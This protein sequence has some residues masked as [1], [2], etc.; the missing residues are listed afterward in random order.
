MTMHGILAFGNIKYQTCLKNKFSFP[1]SDIATYLVLRLNSRESHTLLR[2]GVPQNRPP[3]KHHYLPRHTPVHTSRSMVGIC[4]RNQMK[5][6]Y[7]CPPLKCNPITTCLYCISQNIK[8]RFPVDH[9][10]RTAIPCYCPHCIRDIRPGQ[11]GNPQKRT[12]Q[13]SNRKQNNRLV[14]I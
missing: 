3:C 11:Q 4:E 10:R 7:C 6:F 1:M 14:N 12:D 8:C 9:L 5:P 2:L 13:L